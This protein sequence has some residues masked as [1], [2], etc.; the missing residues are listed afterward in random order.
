VNR[1]EKAEA[2]ERMAA[3]FAQTPHVFVTGYRG[4][5]VNQSSELRRRVRAA[6]GTYEVVKNRLARRAAAETAVARVEAKLRGPV[7]LVSHRTDA[8]VLAKVLTDFAK[9]HP[10]LELIAGVVDGKDVVTTEGLKT[11][12]SL[13]GLPELRAQLLA[14]VLTPATML[15]R[16]LQ[17]PGGQIARA[18]DARREELTGGEG[19]APAPAEN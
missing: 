14:L 4:M 11:L 19:E 16:L 5:T 6:G 13:P 1:T 10:Q 12:A 7:A 3:T 8:V 18:L 15:V 17:T 9:E 2:V